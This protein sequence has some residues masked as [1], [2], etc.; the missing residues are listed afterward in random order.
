M[1]IQ[2]KAILLNAL[3]SYLERMKS[4]GYKYVQRKFIYAIMEDMYDWQKKCGA[5]LTV[6][7]MQEAAKALGGR[8]DNSGRQAKIVF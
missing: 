7:L 5:Y 1:T 8:Y 3:I 4:R 2:Q 6:D